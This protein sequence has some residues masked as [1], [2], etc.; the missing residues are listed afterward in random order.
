MGTSYRWRPGCSALL[1]SLV[2]R[3]W[4]HAQEGAGVC[5]THLNGSPV[6]RQRGAHCCSLPQAHPHHTQKTALLG[7]S[8]PAKHPRCHQAT[9][10]FPASSEDGS[11]AGDCGDTWLLQVLCFAASQCGML[12]L[13]DAMRALCKLSHLV[14]R[15][16]PGAHSSK[17]STWQCSF[18]RA[19]PLLHPPAQ[20]S[21]NFTASGAA[22][23]RGCAGR[24]AHSRHAIFGGPQRCTAR[25]F[26]CSL[27]RNAVSGG[28]ICKC[29]LAA[30]CRKLGAE[31]CKCRRWAWAHVEAA[32]DLPPPYRCRCS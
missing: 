3:E 2:T 17:N 10:L 28:D 4:K 19:R 23:S 6:P 32:V 26:R 18:P 20:L 27:I 7:K 30:G 22:S 12:G 21:A 24:A 1:P 13:T 29:T 9:D 15:G 8:R 5:Q 16:A 25:L 11:S 14:F 31:C